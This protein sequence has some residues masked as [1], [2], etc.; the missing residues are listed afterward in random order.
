[1]DVI[2]D[3]KVLCIYAH[4]VLFVMYHL[5]CIICNVLVKKLELKGEG[6]LKRDSLTPSFNLLENSDEELNNL[7]R[8][9]TLIRVLCIFHFLN[10]HKFN[11]LNIFFLV[12]KKFY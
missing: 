8:S 10:F 5:Q 6:V 4:Y 1:M 9:L 2:V 7:V 11:S 12:F 3:I